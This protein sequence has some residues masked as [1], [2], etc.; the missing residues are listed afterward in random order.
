MSEELQVSLFEEPS[1]SASTET[2]PI[3]FG[4]DL[5]PRLLAVEQIWDGVMLYFREEDGSVRAEA[6]SFQPWLLTDERC[7][8][9][10]AEWAPLQSPENSPPERTPYHWL[11]R[12]PNW[13]AFETARRLLRELHAD[14]IAYRSVAR[15]YLMST[16]RT[17]FKDM[18]YQDLHRLQFDLETVG[19]DPNPEPNRVLM[20]ALSDNR[21][22]QEVLTG[23]ETDLLNEFVKRVQQLNP[24][25]L[26][27]HNLFG[28][29]IPYLM[30]RAQRCRVPLNLG[31]DGSAVTRGQ[32]RNCPIGANSRVFTPAYIHGRHLLD[33]Y[34]AVQR[35]DVARGTMER[36][37][38]KE[39]AITL[40][41]TPENRVQVDRAKLAE[42]WEADP[43]KVQ[44]YALQDVY[45]TRL[46]AEITLPTEFYQTQIIPESLQEL[47]T[48]GTG[49]KVNLLFIR[50]YLTAGSSIPKPQPPRDYPGGYTEVR[51]IGL[52]HHIVKADVESLYPSLM[53]TYEIKPVADTLHV[54]LP[55]L[56]ELTRRRLLAKAKA[57]QCTGTEAAYWD[58]LQGSF[59]ILI[60]SFYGYLGSPFNFNDYDAA[61]QVTLRGQEIVK[62]IAQT[63]EQL[64]GNVVEID[65]DGVYFQPPEEV[66]NEE[67]EEAF[68]AKVG[69]SLPEGI[70]LAHDG[71]YEKMLSLK[72]K[73]YVL[74]DY[75]GKKIFKGAS[76]RSRADEP[77]GRTFL[78]QAVDW[79]LQE[80]P[81][82]VAE[83]YLRLTGALRASE[84]PI[85][86]LCR[87][88][89]V[90]EK[91]LRSEH[92]LYEKAR[93]FKIGDYIEVYQQKGSR[94]QKKSELLGLLTEY[95]PA[96]DDVDY[97]HYVD[98]LYKF[99]CRLR[100][101]FDDFD[102]LFPKPSDTLPSDQMNLFEV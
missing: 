87:R 86:Q 23:T 57:K 59:K 92:R 55:A 30:A 100:E 4:A 74:Q 16:G 51:K 95:D 102:A 53:L 12:F 84:I 2:E 32:E 33:T 22:Y 20:I 96:N 3:L 85:E 81:Q 79:L 98:K 54:F 38:L 75:E 8:I 61:E 89:R 47:A 21:G 17:L 46:L 7:E 82:A 26:E 11:A 83:E 35:Y 10:E 24:D 101:L 44:Q 25:V 27:G 88:E 42:L 15:Q 19:L 31:R 66:R 39:A 93:R 9:P 18:A 77:F 50:A 34:L 80:N 58:G 68:V 73:N 14:M 5:T 37:G 49:E 45:E 70:R 64:G 62:S 72:A 67:Q 60:N 48:T 56:R 99:A 78:S 52:I 65:T 40:G 90:T 97:E 91:S 29:D 43:E 63:I 76:L 94:N 69:E 28:F 71:R 13:Q 6:Q 1:I 36:Y 41:I